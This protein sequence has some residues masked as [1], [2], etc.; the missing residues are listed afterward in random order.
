MWHIQK[1]RFSAKRAKFYACEVLLALKYFHENGIVYRDIK[2]DNIL[3]TTKGHIKIGDYGLCKENMWQGNTTATFCGTP[4]FM[5]PEIISGKQYDR[6][7]DWW[8]LGVLLFQMLLCQS[9]FKGDDEDEIF[10]AIEHDDV[11]YPINMPRQTVLV[12]QALLTKD[13]LSR[14]GSGPR[15]AEEIMDHPYFSDVNFD[16]I[17]NLRV[18]PPYIPEIT[19]EHDY[20]NFDKEF[21]SETPRLTPVDTV[22]TSEMQE[23]FRGFSHISDD[24]AI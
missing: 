6:A 22:L 17:L 3:L 14:L 12:L 20:S 24:A 1:S 7:V 15:D 18:Q 13:P 5:A 21:T 16:D 23:Q 2:L 8:A 4:E 9:P 19:S 10:N 11:R